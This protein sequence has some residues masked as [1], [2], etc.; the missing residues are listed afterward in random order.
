M[1]RRKIERESSEAMDGAKSSII[2]HVR[3]VGVEISGASYKEK[4]R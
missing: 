3:T 4:L 1:H 2:L